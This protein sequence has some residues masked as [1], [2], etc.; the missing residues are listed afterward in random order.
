MQRL[1]GSHSFYCSTTKCIYSVSFLSINI[2]EL[3]ET[4][5]HIFKLKYK[6]A[7]SF[8]GCRWHEL[9]LN[10]QDKYEV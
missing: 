4:V 2:S 5:V 9:L 1:P 6:F 7:P 8:A 10:K 3:M